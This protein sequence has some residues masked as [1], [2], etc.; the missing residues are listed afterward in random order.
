MRS[1]GTYMSLK[2]MRECIAIH[3]SIEEIE[4]GGCSCQ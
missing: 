4:E 3:S 2:V 1:K